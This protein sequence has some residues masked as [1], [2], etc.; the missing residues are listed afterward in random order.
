[1][2]K[3]NDGH[4]VSLTADTVEDKNKIKN[5]T[6][7]YDVPANSTCFCIEDSSVMMLTSA[8]TWEEI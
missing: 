1:M 8:G 3:T 5:G 4:E 6:V 2:I 7:K